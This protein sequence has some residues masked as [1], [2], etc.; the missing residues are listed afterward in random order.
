[1]VKNLTTFLLF[2]SGHPI[3]TPITSHFLP[4]NEHLTGINLSE[5]KIFFVFKMKIALHKAENF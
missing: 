3:A 1:M 2:I 4:T 5:P